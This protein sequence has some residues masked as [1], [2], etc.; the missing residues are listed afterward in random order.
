MLILTALSSMRHRPVKRSVFDAA[1]HISLVRGAGFSFSGRISKSLS[2]R[3]LDVSQGPM[4]VL[5]ALEKLDA[6]TAELRET[7]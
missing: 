6:A 2:N 1:G 7:A 3:W 4:D 5:N